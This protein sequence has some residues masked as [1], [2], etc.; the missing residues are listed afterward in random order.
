RPPDLARHGVHRPEIVL[1]GHREAGLDD[2]HP[3]EIQLPGQPDLFLEVHAAARRLLAV[4]QRGVENSDPVGHGVSLRCEVPVHIRGGIE[5]VNRIRPAWSLGC[6]IVQRNNPPPF[7]LHSTPSYPRTAAHYTLL[8]DRSAS[9]S[10]GGLPGHPGFTLRNISGGRCSR[11]AT[12]VDRSRTPRY[13]SRLIIRW[14][15]P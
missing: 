3:E 11:N 6:R 1:A 12:Q 14:R 2:V 15:T 10:S 9:R 7:R 13:F 4:A 5:T 8:T